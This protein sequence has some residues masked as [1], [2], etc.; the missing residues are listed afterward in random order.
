MNQKF[1]STKG[2]VFAK[3]G[4]PLAQIHHWNELQVLYSKLGFVF[5]EYE[6]EFQKEYIWRCYLESKDS[7]VKTLDSSNIDFDGN[8]FNSELTKHFCDRESYSN[9]Y[10]E[11]F[12][13]HIKWSGYFIPVS[14]FIYFTNPQL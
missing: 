1:L 10:W 6:K 13:N 4:L 8:T 5:I 11:T 7:L 3:A 2:E 14:D 12:M 9:S